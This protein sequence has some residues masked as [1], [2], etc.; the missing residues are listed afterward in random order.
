M[1]SKLAVP[2]MFGLLAGIVG[3]TVLLV[4]GCSSDPT[5][6]PVPTNAPVPTAT[7]EMME[8]TAAAG[9][10]EAIKWYSSN[11]STIELN[12]Y[13]ATYIVENG[14]EYPVD[15]V[16]G[17]TG[18]MKVAFPIGEMEV[19]MEM[20]RIN[21]PDWYEEHIAAGSIV[22]L[23][24]TADNL[25]SGSK[26]QSL[27]K[28]GQGFYVPT[29]VIEANPGLVSVSD[30]PDYVELFTDPEDPSK[31]VIYNCIIG[32]ECQKI[33]RAKWYAYGLFDTYNMAE[34]GSA[35]ALDASIVGAYEAGEPVLSYYW[36]PTTIVNLRDMTRLEEPAWTPECQAA[37]DAA[38]E[39]SPY[40]STIGCGYPFGDVHVGVHSSL[41]ERAP[42]VTEFLAN[43]FLGANALGT[44][45]VWKIENDVEWRDAAVYYLKNNRDIWT[46]WI[47]DANADE[48]IARVDEA[49]AAEF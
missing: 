4:A 27:A 11:W 48:I 36:E 5:A 8:P 7:A 41:V 24:G 18:T 3:L 29:Y 26:G 45:E 6:T 12:N 9:P 22:D 39:S 25:P 17:V 46:A 33:N 15:L 31:G 34:P 35:G 1:R 13:V 32:W 28:G 42:D 19:N 16:T 23:A 49:L 14:Y 44:L 21:I 43:F 37:L 2:R 30:L 10:K 47:T 20:W 38:V 40:Q